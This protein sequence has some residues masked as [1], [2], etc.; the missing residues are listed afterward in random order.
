MTH[1]KVKSI[2]FIFSL[3]FLFMGC[4]TVSARKPASASL[5]WEAA[6][7]CGNYRV[8]DRTDISRYSVYI[9]PTN[10][11]SNANREVLLIKNSADYSSLKAKVEDGCHVDRNHLVCA[12]EKVTVTLDMNQRPRLLSPRGDDV[13]YD[14][15]FNVPYAPALGLI[16][17]DYTGECKTGVVR[18]QFGGFQTKSSD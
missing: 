13:A 10:D 2:P 18:P 7:S 14:V 8:S 3:A 12:V 5:N 15:N 16:K 4:S 17:S 1:E 11:S 9:G 6:M